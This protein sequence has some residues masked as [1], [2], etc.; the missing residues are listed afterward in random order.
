MKHCTSVAS[1][2]HRRNRNYEYSISLLIARQ[3]RSHRAE[4][5]QV[6]L[7]GDRAIVAQIDFHGLFNMEKHCSWVKG[8]TST[9]VKR[10]LLS[11][12]RST[13]EAAVATWH[14]LPV[15]R[16]TNT[17]LPIENYSP[18]NT[19]IKVIPTLLELTLVAPCRRLSGCHPIY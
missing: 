7:H 15:Y 10:L 8:R 9:T 4:G 5:L 12:V 14:R 11:R 6:R 13:P 1:L 17:S 19:P 2:H 18:S 16:M 3:R